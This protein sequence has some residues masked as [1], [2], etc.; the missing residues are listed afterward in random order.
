MMDLVR[1]LEQALA[2]SVDGGPG[3]LQ[4]PL[5]GGGRPLAAP[6]ACQEALVL[7]VEDDADG[8]EAVYGQPQVLAPRTR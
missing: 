8:A 7:L 2:A 4:E 6:C 3:P 5:H 1:A